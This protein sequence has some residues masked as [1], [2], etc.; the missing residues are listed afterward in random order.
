MPDHSQRIRQGLTLL[1][2]ARDDDLE[3]EVLQ[4]GVSGAYT[5]LVDLGAGLKVL[6]LT[7]ATSAPWVLQRAQRELLF[8]RQL[9]PQV[10]LRVP[11]LLA[12]YSD[13]TG[14]TALL[15]VAYRPPE[16]PDRWGKAHYRYVA[17]QLA[18]FHT[19]F[20]DTT[21]KLA[22]YPWLKRVSPDGL[23]Q[24]LPQAHAAWQALFEQ[25]RL[26]E[27]FTAHTRQMIAHLLPRVPTLSERI[28]AFPRTLCHGDCHM[29][30]LLHDQQG[31]L[32][33]ADWQEIG[34]GC[35][36]EDLAFFLQRAQASGGGV[37]YASAVEAY[38]EQLEKLD[39]P[40][41]LEAIRRVV[42][43]SELCTRLV[44]WPG[45]LNQASARQVADHLE[46]INLLAQDL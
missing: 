9:A 33:W 29:G 8:Y 32:L 22:P 18:F 35:G 6:K 45:Y 30:N 23:K 26:A 43:V 11:Q 38:Q 27:T 16:P 2:Q 21:E 46:R 44:H 17:Q 3:F 25:P 36:P 1:R 40:V 42:A 39:R 24:H 4:G 13:G 5:Y 10:S 37:P 12:S 31:D 28:T 7:E 19:L 20:W 41:S 14:A 34:V 15:F